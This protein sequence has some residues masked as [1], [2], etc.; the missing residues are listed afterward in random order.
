MPSILELQDLYN[1]AL[2]REIIEKTKTCGLTWNSLGGTQF[3]ATEVQSST[4]SDI[5][6]D[7]FITKTQIGNATYK[8]TLDIKKDAVAYVTVSDGPLAY[9]NRDSVVKELYDIVEIVV[10]EMDNKLKETI[11]F[12][13]QITDCRS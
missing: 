13:Q 1:E 2:V 4:P 9:T 8:Y 3:Q 6:W 11:R 5:T 12:V 10:L 7:F